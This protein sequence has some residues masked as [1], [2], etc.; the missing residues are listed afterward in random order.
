LDLVIFDLDGTLVEFKYRYIEAKKSVLHLLETF[1]ISLPSDV[2]LKPTQDIF[3][4]IA[5]RVKKNG[6]LDLDEVMMKVNEVIAQYEMEAATSTTIFQDAKD[7]LEALKSMNIKIAL[8]TNNSKR[9]AEFVLTRFQIK[10]FF[11]AVVT[12]NDGFKLKPYPDGILW[13]LS[14]VSVTKR[15]TLFVGDSL[16]DVKAGRA[17]GVIVA[18]LKTPFFEP[19]S[20]SEI[21]PDYLV[22]RLSDI[23]LLI[24]RL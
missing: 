4:E 22:D 5:S 21:K 3:D 8:V 19:L 17:A 7:V 13:V 11:D 9:A 14:K 2:T 18:A 20:E 23:L 16:I 15:K 12:R 10:D 6:S 24:R 1:G